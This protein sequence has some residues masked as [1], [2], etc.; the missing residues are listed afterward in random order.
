LGYSIAVPPNLNFLNCYQKAE[1]EAKRHRRG[2]WNHTFSKPIKAS[3]LSGSHL[4]FQRV[5]GR[6]QRIGE[7][8]SSFWL[9]LDKK[10]ALRIQ[11]KYLDHFTT[12]QPNELL[13]KKLIARGWIYYQKNE[14][15]MSVKHPAS[16]LIQNTD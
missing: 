12:Y 2:I 14:F 7:S 6:V 3:T 15:R 5:I 11:K 9:N 16:L 13:N 4:G 1:N 8:Q 10:F